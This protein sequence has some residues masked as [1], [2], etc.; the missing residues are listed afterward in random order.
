MNKKITNKFHIFTTSLLLILLTSCSENNNSGDSNALFTNGV[1]YTNNYLFYSSAGAIYAVDPLSPDTSIPIEPE[2]ANAT[3]PVMLPMIS[4]QNA[5]TRTRLYPALVYAR[6]GKIWAVNAFAN[7]NLNRAQLSNES[8]AFHICD[9]QGWRIWRSD[10]EFGIEYH[11]T[12]AGDDNICDKYNWADG[13]INDDDE[14]TV[15]LLMDATDSPQPFDTR[16]L[17]FP[18]IPGSLETFSTYDKATKSYTIIGQLVLDE[19]AKTLIW[20]DKDRNPTSKIVVA[21]NVTSVK[22]LQ[23]SSNEAIFLNIDQQLR[24][25]DSKSK[26]LSGVLL[27]FDFDD[28][29]PYMPVENYNRDAVFV[30][31][32]TGLYYMPRDASISPELIYQLPLDATSYRFYGNTVSAFVIAEQY[33]AEKVVYAITKNGQNKTELYRTTRNPNRFIDVNLS[34]TTRIIL[35]DYSNK[36]IKI[37]SEDG[38]FVKQLENHVIIDYLEPNTIDINN[39]RNTWILTGKYIGNTELTLLTIDSDGNQLVEL[40]TVPNLS[41]QTV[42]Q[43]L[44]ISSENTLITLPINN[45]DEIYFANLK[46]AN[47]LIRITDND[48]NDKA[49]KTIWHEEIPKSP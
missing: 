6:E 34:R 48:I 30:V 43:R 17:K 16:D 38:E 33:T 21:E 36:L 1:N 35:E 15:T 29:Y 19:T 8:Q 5:D 24:L 11:Y 22:S 27:S 18:N 7:D 47:S 20:Y 39:N 13:T 12:L 49:I 9:A 14:K 44:L 4:S 46:V 37:A 2:E 31:G 23:Y 42:S 26:T 10:I 32:S 3:A 40:G 28:A 41:S 45:N 25:F